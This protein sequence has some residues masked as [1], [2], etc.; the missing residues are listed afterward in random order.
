MMIHNRNYQILI[1]NFISDHIGSSCGATTIV[2]EFQLLFYR[3]GEHIAHHLETTATDSKRRI[4]IKSWQTH[5]RP[6]LLYRYTN[7][8][9]SIDAITT[10]L[11]STS[12]HRTSMKMQHTPSQQMDTCFPNLP[13]LLQQLQSRMQMQQAIS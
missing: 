13:H 2:N 12:T 1:I 4:L 9:H 3:M 5:P 6:K 8:L 10:L 7:E 11:L